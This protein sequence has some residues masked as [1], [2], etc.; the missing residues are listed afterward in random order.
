MPNPIKAAV[1]A[2]R[3]QG[4]WWTI[5]HV[6]EYVVHQAR[7]V[8]PFARYY[9]RERREGFD[10]KHG[11]D[12]TGLV[13]IVELPGFVGR[14]DDIP[15]YGTLPASMIT[16]ILRAVDV[17]HAQ[18]VFVDLGSGKGRVV[19][20]AGESPYKRVVGV[21]IAGPLHEIAQRN[22]ERYRGER[23]AGAV[24]LVCSDVLEWELPPDPLVFYI[25]NA[26]SPRVLRDFLARV[27]AS[28][29]AH[30]RDVYFMYAHPQEEAVLAE[31]GFL[32]EVARK[33]G[34]LGRDIV[35]TP[36]D[37]IGW[38]LYRARR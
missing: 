6:P 22:L 16:D 31:Q 35:S 11:T 20:L 33:P 25:G 27:E 32:H 28:L 34:E 5:K 23:R 17:D 14:F 13:Q 21:E 15:G 4:V 9:W 1:E 38:V 8:V 2:I 12:T 30:P 29:R 19:L 3:E 7:S 18:Y 26:L 36:P 10:A 24:E 37:K